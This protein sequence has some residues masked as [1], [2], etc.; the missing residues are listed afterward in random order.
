MDVAEQTGIQME[1]AV[2]IRSVV[3][4]IDLDLF[5]FRLH[6][7]IFVQID[8]A[9]PKAIA[10]ICAGIMI[11][12]WFMLRNVVHPICKSGSG[13]TIGAEPHAIIKGRACNVVQ[14]V[15]MLGQKIIDIGKFGG[16][17]RRGYG[18]REFRFM[19]AVVEIKRF[20]SAL[21]AAPEFVSQQRARS[22]GGD[23]GSNPYYSSHQICENSVVAITAA[24]H[25]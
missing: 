14:R 6:L 17:T 16:G 2:L 21:A 24:W 23:P 13:I 20:W 8:R 5:H 1:Y 18:C 10:N 3:S 25:L 7:Q 9:Q 22:H 12:C 19:A 11:K 4:F 15:G